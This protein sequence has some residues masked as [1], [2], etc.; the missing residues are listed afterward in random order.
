MNRP[1]TSVVAAFILLSSESVI[2]SQWALQVNLGQAT[3]KVE[4]VDFSDSDLSIGVAG[5]YALNSNFALELRYDDFGAVEYGAAFDR[6]KLSASAVSSGIV[7]MLPIQSHFIGFAKMGAA[8]CQTEISDALGKNTSNNLNLY[9]GFGAEYL[10]TESMSVTAEYN[11]IELEAYAYDMTIDYNI[12]NLTLGF[13][14]YL[15]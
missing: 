2:A 15:N 13:R 11:I 12:A 9:Y 10:I 14:Y 1:I 7:A 8:N 4:A 3:Q 6:G 5:L